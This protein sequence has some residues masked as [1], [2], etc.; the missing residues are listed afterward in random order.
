MPIAASTLLLWLAPGLPAA[1][2]LAWFVRPLRRF[3]PG[4]AALAPLPALALAL[5]HLW[6]PGEI[7]PAQAPFLVLGLSLGLDLVGGAFLLLVAFLWLAAGVYARAHHRDD[8]R[9]AGFF[10]LWAAT[11]AGNVGVVL[12]WDL[13]SFY[14]AFA[15]LTLAGWGLVVHR[16]DAEAGRAGR[17]YIVLALLG[18]V[19]LLSARFVQDLGITP[20]IAMLSFSNFGSARHPASSRVREAVERIKAMSP[21]LAVDGEMQAD[22]AVNAQLL[23]DT[24]PFSDLKEPANVLIFPNLASANVSYKLLAQLG[25]AEVIGPV[26]LGMSRP[27]HV[28]QRGSTTQEVVNLVTVASVDAQRRS[29]QT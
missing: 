18:E 23:R 2:A 29:P 27:V 24:Y 17:I 7:L 12:A 28:L 9:R 19:A 13:L 11:L 6:V 16:R 15:L 21:G 22:T 25:G 10:S 14:L 26:L 4:L 1:V 8:P 5:V 3:L 20:R